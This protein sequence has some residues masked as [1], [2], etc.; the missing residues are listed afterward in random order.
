MRLLVINGP[1]LNLLGTREPDI[2]GSD[3]LQDLEGSWRR[4]GSRI[5]VGITAF[6]SNH[7]G[8]IIDVIHAE[9][10]RC[11]G[12]VINPGALS[13]TSYAIYDAL[14]AVGVPT[15]EVHI[16]NIAEREEWRRTSVTAPAALR[17]ISGRGTSG[18]LDAI[19]L[20][21]SS[22]R[23]PATTYPYGEHPDQILDVRTP[24]GEV[25]GVVCLI[26]GGFWR[27]VWGRD[28]MDPMAAALTDL[29]W[30]TVNIEYRRGANS[31][32][33]ATADIASA[34][35][36]V[37]THLAEDEPAVPQDLL[38][39]P[40]L[41]GHSAGGYL[42]IRQA[43]RDANLRGAVG[44]GAVIDLVGLSADRPDDDP[45]ALFLGSTKTENP[46]RWRDAA[47]CTDPLSPTVLIH[48]VE[49]AETPLAHAAEYVTGRD[50][51]SLMQLAGAGHMDVIDP[52]VAAFATVV[53]ALE[54]LSS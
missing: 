33:T 48:G 3:T 10:S 53:G 8:A 37:R 19:N 21:S 54:E 36:W 31:F 6:Q 2:Y 20:L 38:D 42:A 27:P 41:V 13:H 1:N 30:A 44:L 40:F 14:V 47:L 18:Y 52:S 15:V 23:S 28:I 39:S 43:C 35:T 17:V 51:V 5:Q 45:I 50:R 4:H 12:I 26:H 7:E 46:D 29:G 24:E 22:L 32:E 49:D 25:K 34:T 9:S 11:D 16:S